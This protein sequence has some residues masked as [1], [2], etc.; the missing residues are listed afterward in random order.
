M[1]FVDL[2]HLGDEWLEFKKQRMQNLLKIAS[3]DEALYRE[4]MLSLGYPGN[5]VN[6]LELALIL[7]YSE[8][9][10]LK[11]REIIERA[12]LYRAGF[13]DDKDGLP[14]YF[15]LSLRM[16]KPVWEYRGTRPANFPEKRIKGITDL[17]TKSV[18]RRLVN[19]FEDNVRSQKESKNPKSAL[20]SI[21]DFEGIGI[22]RKEEMFFNI[23]MPFLMVFSKDK[24]VCEFLKL[25]FE[26]YPPLHDNKLTKAFKNEHPDYEIKTVKE[27]MGVVFFQKNKE[28]RVM[29]SKLGG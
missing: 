6:F 19:L 27:Y 18:E 16:S 2:C 15:D 3:P 5:K 9:K 21:M 24:G 23:V 22:Q 28:V 26:C 10:K 20:R 25:M 12:L 8:I 4:I 29:D 17:L 1:L 13:S 11:E 7:P 14:D